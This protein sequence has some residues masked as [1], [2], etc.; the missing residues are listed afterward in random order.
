MAGTTNAL[1][2]KLRDMRNRY[3]AIF[4]IEGA[5]IGGLVYFALRHI[6]RQYFDVASMIPQ[7]PY[8]GIVAN[9]VGIGIVLPVV[10][11]VTISVVK[12]LQLDKV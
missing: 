6:V 12:G 9:L 10:V 1:S 8:V 5:A 3:I 2:L 11:L 7:I 4:A